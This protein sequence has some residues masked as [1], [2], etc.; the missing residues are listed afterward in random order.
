MRLSLPSRLALVA[1]HVLVL[2]FLY[3]PLVVVARLSFNPVESLS[4]PPKGWTLDWWRQA[5]GHRRP[6]RRAV[7]LGQGGARGHRHRA[8]PRH[9]GRVRDA[10]LLVLRQERGLVPD[11]AADRAARHRHRG[12]VAEQLL[13]HA[14][15][16]ACS[17]SASGSVST[18]WSSPTRRSASSSRTTTSSPACADRRRTC[19][20][21]RPIWAPT[22]PR[23]SGT[24]RSRWCGRRCS[25]AA[26]WR[27]RSAS[28]RSSSRRSPR[29]PG[30]ET[31][32]QWIFNRIGRSSDV[33]A[34]QRDGDVRDGGVDPAGL[35]GAASVRRRSRI[36]VRLTTSPGGLGLRPPRR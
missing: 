17:S 18:R 7:E 34:R 13:A 1:L 10:A 33:T 9:A 29:V 32:P 16:S 20:R 25:P 35:A 5:L 3:V 30:Y 15:T 6:A 2:V 11:R 27:S 26:S 21:R 24:S 28:T 31:L 36:V 22:A 19:S 12:R 14:S 23:R 4:W 8:G